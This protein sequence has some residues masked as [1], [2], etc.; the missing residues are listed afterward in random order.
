MVVSIKLQTW[1]YQRKCASAGP[2]SY[3]CLFNAE[4]Q[5]L[6]EHD[7][8]GSGNHYKHLWQ[9]ESNTSIYFSQSMI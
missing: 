7:P 9:G 5:L 6:K 8:Q 4:Y 3:T 2:G 1:P